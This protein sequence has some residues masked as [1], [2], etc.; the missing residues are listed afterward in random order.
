MQEGPASVQ[1]QYFKSPRRQ[2]Q[3]FDAERNRFLTDLND[4]TSQSHLIAAVSSE[5]S[6][7]RDD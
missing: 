3:S 4:K 1:G 7:G 2:E 5:E 6:K